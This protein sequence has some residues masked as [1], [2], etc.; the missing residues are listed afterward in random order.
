MR[1]WSRGLLHFLLPVQLDLSALAT[2]TVWGEGFG[3]RRGGR[4]QRVCVVIE[5]TP[6][7]SS[8][9]VALYTARE[10]IPEKTP[11]R[12]DKM[13]E[14]AQRQT[15]LSVARVSTMEAEA[16]VVVSMPQGRQKASRKS[17]SRGIIA[18]RWL[19]KRSYKEGSQFTKVRDE[20]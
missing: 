1:Q 2:S 4:K 19:K 20:K 9:P 6:P 14:V 10:P 7:C 5:A 3:G 13:T 18:E 8:Q 15:A 12:I 17:T 16:L 11:W